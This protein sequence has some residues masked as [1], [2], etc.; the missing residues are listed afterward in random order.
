MND[1]VQMELRFIDPGVEYAD[2]YFGQHNYELNET[3]DLDASVNLP[4]GTLDLNGAVMNVN[5]RNAVGMDAQ[6]HFTGLHGYNFVG[7]TIELEH[8][9]LFA[10]L[11][12]ARA[13]RNGQDVIA[14]EHAYVLNSDNSN[15]DNFLEF[16]PRDLNVTATVG[17]N[18]MGD[19]TAG[20]D[21]VYLD[22]AL[23][24][25]VALDIPLRIGMDNLTF[26][27]TLDLTNDAIEA[28]FN[29]DLSLWLK[30]EFPIGAR[31]TLR[32]LQDGD[33]TTVVE[34]ASIDAASTTTSVGVTQ[35]AES[36]IAIAL[37][38]ELI[39]RVNST[40][41]LVI[42]VGLNTP[43]S[44]TAVGIYDTY[45]IDFKLIANGTYTFEIGQ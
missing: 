27:D 28:L 43:G 12:I 23:S 16:L 42:D 21:F 9:P 25:T 1:V 3:V 37:N 44:G 14:E 33:L 45:G 4:E 19:I 8:A 7:N 26:R 2:G 41:Q 10:P 29:G 24:A 5:I 34:G 32:L 35:A 22:D 38:P 31:C 15:L 30:N 17:L 11:N 6:L 18:P 36:W 39:G 40:H 13:T 20:N